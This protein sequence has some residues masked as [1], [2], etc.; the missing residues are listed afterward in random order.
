[1][2]TTIKCLMV[3]VGLTSLLPRITCAAESAFHVKQRASVDAHKAKLRSLVF[4]PDGKLLA[5]TSEDRTTRLR[6]VIDGSL[7]SVR[8]PLPGYTSVA[9][10]TDGKSLFI[11][12]GS[13]RHTLD[14]FDVP[15]N[16]L[17]RSINTGHSVEHVPV[18]A[19]GRQVATGAFLDPFL[20]VWNVETGAAVKTLTSP[21]RPGPGADKNL[22]RPM[23]YTAFSPDG[24]Y[25]VGCAATSR[26]VAI[27]T[28]WDSKTFEV[29]SRFVANANRC[30]SLRFSTDSKVLAIGTEDGTVKL[31]N[32]AA[33]VKACAA[34][35]AKKNTVR[36]IELLI[37]Q[38]DDDGFQ[39][40]EA[41]EKEL[42]KIG[43]AAEQQLIKA[44]ATTTSAEVRARIT[45][46]LKSIAGTGMK[47]L[48]S[49]I[50]VAVLTEEQIGGV[51]SLAFSHDGKL[52]AAGSWKHGTQQ[53]QL[54]VWEPSRP[55]TLVL[56]LDTVGIE[57]LD[58]S[59]D[60][61]TL[62]TGMQDGKVTIWAVWLL[63]QG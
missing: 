51:R 27:P 61:K 44:K 43:V 6:D 36:Q 60:G 3:M 4:S 31:W 59:P 26:Y 38:L 34:R 17:V 13:G 9:F 29:R 23:G 45:R 7:K 28:V 32:I 12:R 25:I 37:T 62:V 14:I 63:L 18:S 53:G 22:S 47:P 8:K 30:F 48:E 1:M 16:R 24:R 55:A 58:F 42:A 39:I 21:T 41:A 52:L 11:A 50:P 20:K 54:R 19:D 10:S 5:S 15:R 46:L 2:K 35:A 49:L 40:R 57:A 33:V 56:N